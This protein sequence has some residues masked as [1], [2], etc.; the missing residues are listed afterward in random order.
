MTWLKIPLLILSVILEQSVAQYTRSFIM[1]ITNEREFQ[2][3]TTTCLP[4]ATLTISNIRQCQ[5]ICLG[6]TQCIAATFQQSISSCQ[7][8]ANTLNETNNLQV[9]AGT[10]TMMVIFRTPTPPGKYRYKTL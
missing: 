9:N 7:L 8:F 1:S 10:V 5:I 2:C 3:A 4:L 6:Q